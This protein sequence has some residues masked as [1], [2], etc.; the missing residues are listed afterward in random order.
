MS[1]GAPSI[2]VWRAV[3]D[4]RLHWRAWDDGIVVYNDMTGDTHLLDPQTARLLR[5]LEHAPMAF[6]ALCRAL[7]EEGDETPAEDLRPWCEA[8]LTQLSRLSLI[9]P[10]AP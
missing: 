10:A 4:S 6:D 2:E 8:T 1:D 5:H 9:E 3:V 7:Q